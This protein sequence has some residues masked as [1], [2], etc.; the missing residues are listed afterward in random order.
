M[1]TSLFISAIIVAISVV[2]SVISVRK[3]N[4]AKNQIKLYQ[5]FVKRTS[6]KKLI[7]ILEKMKPE[8]IDSEI[9]IMLN[10]YFELVLRKIDYNKITQLLNDL[11]TSKHSQVLIE[12]L[13]KNIDDNDGLLGLALAKSIGNQEERSIIESFL[14]TISKDQQDREY[15]VAYRELE[16]EL[17]NTLVD[18]P[19]EYRAPV[20][21]AIR[22]I[23]EKIKDQLNKR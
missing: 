2:I 15:L 19:E 17:E 22:E 16:E 12:A 8:I 10:K 20:R 7:A 1:N 11:K 3:N 14:S 18:Y 21:K 5:C 6:V 9:I 23:G 4:L 13:R